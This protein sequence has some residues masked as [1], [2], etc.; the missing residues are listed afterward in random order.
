MPDITTHTITTPVNKHKVVLKSS[1]TGFD[2]EAINT[3]LFSDDPQSVTGK[4]LAESMRESIKRIVVSVDGSDGEG[5]PL[6][7]VDLV[8][9]MAVRDCKFVKDEVEK[10]AN[11][12]EEEVAEKKDDSGKSTETS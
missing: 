12:T 3:A 1:I 9:N 7:I 6:G 4:S 8:Y 2:D 10:V 5:R 11:P